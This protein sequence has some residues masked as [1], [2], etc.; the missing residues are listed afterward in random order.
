MAT[1]NQSVEYDSGDSSTNLFEPDV[2]LPSQFF[3]RGRLGVSG[4]ER[5][6]MAAILSDG[7]ESYIQ[8]ATAPGHIKRK[9]Q[10]ESAI[11]WVNTRDPGGYVFSFDSVCE[12]LG[13]DPEYLRLGLAR[14]VDAIYAERQSG[15]PMRSVWKKIRRPRK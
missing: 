5:K 13:I 8:Q 10:G 11:D 1:Y 14:Y 6:L 3:S 2:L 9:S 4:G 15:K 12:C 7:I